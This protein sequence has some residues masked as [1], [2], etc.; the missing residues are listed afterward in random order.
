MKKIGEYTTRGS[1][2]ADD[3]INRIILDDGSYKTGYR[4]VEFV[5]APHDMDNTNIRVYAAK[6]L[7][8]DEQTPGVNW[9][10]DRN[11][12][13]G[14]AQYAL[15]ANSSNGPNVF[16]LVDPDNLVIQDLFVIGSEYAS[17]IKLNYF[18]RMDKYEISDW[19]GALSMVRNRSQA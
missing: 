16:S 3:T 1:I 4:V 12:E 10:W 18:I 15:D 5:I 14:W 6:L 19:K 2:V 11:G 17:D 9:N 8:N 7:T 13:I